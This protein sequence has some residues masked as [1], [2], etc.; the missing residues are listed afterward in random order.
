MTHSSQSW[1]NT[2]EPSWHASVKSS[3]WPHQKVSVGVTSGAPELPGVVWPGSVHQ[4]AAWDGDRAWWRD[5]AG[6]GPG[7]QAG[8]RN[9]AGETAGSPVEVGAGLGDAAVCSA[10]RTDKPGTCSPSVGR[11][12]TQGPWDR[13]DKLALQ[14]QG[15]AGSQTLRPPASTPAQA[16]LSLTDG[17]AWPSPRTPCPDLPRLS[18]A[19][20]PHIA[21]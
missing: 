15:T 20:G 12:P 2:L 9:L 19:P 1:H 7:P 16:S 17:S 13:P 5:R 21:A 6:Q 3:H 4:A 8:H 18:L 14:A 11:G 10:Q